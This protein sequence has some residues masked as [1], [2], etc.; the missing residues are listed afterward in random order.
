MS[1]ERCGSFLAVKYGNEIIESK[2]ENKGFE[3]PYVIKKLQ[4]SW[5]KSGISCK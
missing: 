2:I 3:Y 4:W 1:F 5:R